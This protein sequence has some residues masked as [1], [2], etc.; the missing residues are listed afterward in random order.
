M[1][2]TSKVHVGR[3][4]ACCKAT[5]LPAAAPCSITMPI[6]SNP[7]KIIRTKQ[8]LKVSDG[9]G[10]C[11][12]MKFEAEINQHFRHWKVNEAHFSAVSHYFL[13]MD[14]NFLLGRNLRWWS[15]ILDLHSRFCRD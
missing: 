14:S 6:D 2:R 3:P 1:E 4:Q 9:H 5:V 8:V 10:Q 7:E 13:M 11:L 12:L 15:E